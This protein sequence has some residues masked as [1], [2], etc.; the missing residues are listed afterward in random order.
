MSRK[1][2]TEFEFAPPPASSMIEALRGVGYSTETAIADL[3][4][5]SISAGANN[6]WINFWWAGRDS[7]VSTLDDGEGMEEK[8]LSSAMR[9]GSQSPLDER[10]AHDLGRFGLGLKTASFSQCRR[11]TVASRRDGR[12]ATRRWDLDHVARV[13]DWQLL[14][15]PARGSE[16]LIKPLEAIE[17]GTLVLWECMDRVVGKSATSDQRSH[18]SFL[19]LV[20]KVEQHL[21]MVFHRF[22]EGAPPELRIFINGD[23]EDHRVRAWDPFMRHHRATLSTPAERI[24]TPRG[25][26]EIQGFVLPHKDR[27]VRNEFQTGAGPGGWTAQQGFYV[28]RNRRMLVSG[29]WLGLGHSRTWTREEPYKLARLRLDIP[30]TADADWKI[31][32]KKSVA[33]P[34]SYLEYRL[35]DLADCVRRDARQVFAHRGTYGQRSPIPDLQRAWKAIERRDSVLYRVDR[36]HPVVKRVLDQAGPLSE[37]VEAMLRVLEETVPV[38]RIWLDTVEKGQV[39]KGAFADAPS[40]DLEAILRVLYRHLV[41]TVGLTPD[42]ARE[43]L[44]TTEPFQ[45]FPELVEALPDHMDR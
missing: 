18:D 38:Q 36:D 26:V 6:V 44:L 21:A 17:Q 45:N 23:D 34:P 24:P 4:D 41:K 7:Y 32:I 29:D 20:D 3:I 2:N 28:Y 25:D 5:N 40:A 43:Q 1:Q 27:L 15:G 37:A 19:R 16:K 13:D 9:P 11:L 33:H 22:L 35:R 10:S 31:D 12:L 8:E 14:T 42:K 39:Q 30:N